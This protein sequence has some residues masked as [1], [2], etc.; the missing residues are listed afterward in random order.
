MTADTGAHPVRLETERL[1]LRIATAEDAPALVRYYSENRDFLA[2][3]EPARAPEF[4]GAEFW[5]EQAAIHHREFHG[6]RSLRLILLPRDSPREVIGSANFSQF[7]RGIFQACHLGYSLAERAEGQGLMREA[8]GAAIPFV[9]GPLHMHRVMANHM[10]HNR[11]SGALLRALGFVV[12]GYA[13]DYL[14]INGRWE[15][16]VLTSLTNPDWKG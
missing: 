3:W 7:V 1:V 15:D 4:Y 2:P 13:R 11:R 16:H 9:F 6:D 14:R 10:P 12:D 5:R 8:L